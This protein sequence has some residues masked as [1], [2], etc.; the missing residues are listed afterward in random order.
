MLLTVLASKAPVQEFVLGAEVRQLRNASLPTGAPSA[1]RVNSYRSMQVFTSMKS[2]TRHQA[3]FES[4]DNAVIFFCSM[5]TAESLLPSLKLAGVPAVQQ[6]VRRPLTPATQ[7][8]RL[9]VLR[10]SE[11][12]SHAA[13]LEATKLSCLLQ[14]EPAARICWRVSVGAGTH[15]GHAHCYW[16]RGIHKGMLH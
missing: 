7:H 3:G 2:S 10:L 1:N 4:I 11:T 5:P 13:E 6:T 12:Q 16:K 14:A 9:L 8:G 15:T